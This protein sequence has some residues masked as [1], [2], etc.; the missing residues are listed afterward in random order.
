MNPAKCLCS[1][2]Y[3]IRIDIAYHARCMQEPRSLGLWRNNRYFK[4]LYFCVNFA[5]RAILANTFLFNKWILSSVQGNIP[6]FDIKYCSE[7]RIATLFPTAHQVDLCSQVCSPHCPMFWS[8]KT[9]E[10]RPRAYWS[11]SSSFPLFEFGPCWKMLNC[12]LHGNS[13]ICSYALFWFDLITLY[14]SAV[15]ALTQKKI[16]WPP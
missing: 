8:R 15:I 11:F 10:N 14:L 12:M 1:S 4:F 9:C 2:G 7:Y 13:R 5:V 6:R 3:N 16:W